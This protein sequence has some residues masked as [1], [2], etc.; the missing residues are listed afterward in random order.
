MIFLILS[1]L[2]SSFLAVVFKL[3]AKYE[4]N[5]FHAIVVNYIVCV[6]TGSLE[7][8]Y[9]PLGL[10]TVEQP[11]FIVA[12]FLGTLFI[13]GFY[14]VGL[15]IQKFGVAVSSVTQK[16]SLLISVPFAI[17][18]YNEKSGLGVWTGLAIAVAAV[19]MTRPPLTA[20]LLPLWV[21]VSSGL[22]EIALQYVEKGI[23][24]PL[25]QKSDGQFTVALFGMAA[26]MGICMLSYQL[27]IQK[28]KFERKSLIA[29]ILLGIP[30]YGSIFFLMKALASMSRLSFFLQ[31]LDFSFSKT[32]SQC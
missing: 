9:F 18:A 6:I 12:A 19:V 3:F 28:V 17:I 30:N 20:Y 24:A 13:T 4:I 27:I 7:L 2:L 15:T 10:K 32:N 16:M 5:T 29:G 11:W 22:I 26:T 25:G 8:G 21:F 31:L 14:A 1:I 23:F